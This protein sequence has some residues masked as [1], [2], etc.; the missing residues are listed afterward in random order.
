[1]QGIEEI[2]V[3]G[4]TGGLVLSAQS[5]AGRVHH[6]DKVIAA[7]EDS[8]F[9]YYEEAKKVLQG[10]NVSL[11]GLTIGENRP[12][13]LPEF[14]DQIR[15]VLK[16]LIKDAKKGQN[17]T[18]RFIA[19]GLNDSSCIDLI[20]YSKIDPREGNGLVLADLES[21]K[22][23]ESILAKD[24]SLPFIVVLN[25]QQEFDGKRTDGNLIIV[26]I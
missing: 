18:C 5:E 24:V 21:A 2:F 8:N 4:K 9:D 3:D 25:V 10:Y 26:S 6:L 20:D 11:L 12:P 13:G 14:K 23:L 1:L 22:Q 16:N 19:L 7:S 17:C 15:I